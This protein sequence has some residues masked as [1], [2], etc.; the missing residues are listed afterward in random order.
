MTEDSPGSEKFLTLTRRYMSKGGQRQVEKAY[1]FAREAHRGQ[2][3]KSGES[4]AE[5]PIAVATTLAELEL[6]PDTVGAAL[7]HDVV[8]DTPFS[9]NDIRLQFGEQIAEIIDG[10]TKLDRFEFSS[11]EEQQAENMRKMLISMA[12]DVRVILI[13]LADRLHN[14]ETISALRPERQREISAETLEIYAPLAHRF[15]ISQ[16]EWKL[17]D[18]AFEVLY[19]K[20]YRQIQKMVSE[21]RMERETYMKQVT[22]QISEQLKKHRIKAEVSGRVKHFY[23]IYEKMVNRGIE[24]DEIMDLSAVRVMVESVKDCYGA[25]GVIHSTWKPV[26]GRFKDYIA[27]PKLNMYRSLH[28]VVMSLEGRPLEIQIRTREMHR[29]SE[30]GIAAHW[31]YKE[32]KRKDHGGRAWLKQVMDWQRELKD[33]TE[34]MKTLKIDLFQDEVFV[35]TPGGKLI[36]LSRGATPIDFAY[37][38][39]TE[40]GHNCV[41]A[42]VN[43]KMV[44]LTYQI[45]TGDIVNIMTSKTSKGPSRDWL[46]IVETSRARNKIRQWFSRERREDERQEGKE[47]LDREM[48]KRDLPIKGK[49]VER[50]LAQVGEDYHYARVEDLYRMIG[51]RHISPGHVV[52]KIAQYLGLEK[53]SVIVPE[54]EAET[55]PP[56]VRV[57][58][59]HIRQKI[60]VHGVDNALVTVARC[61]SPQPG[62]DIVGFVTRGRGVSVHLRECTNVRELSHEVDRMIDVTWE[63]ATPELRVAEIRVKAMDRPKLVRDITTVLGDQQINILSASFS[64]DS[65]HMASSKYLFEIAG[66]VHLEEIIKELRKIDSVYDVVE[67][68]ST[69]E[70]G[71]D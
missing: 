60:R 36:S 57:V 45:Q 33:P 50:V 21:R 56:G 2:C 28:T 12:G 62:D 27:M 20:R 47:V 42:K 13:K 1:R 8:E 54:T 55:P 67:V 30:F 15:G 26:P 10:V 70:M 69:E 9:L 58:D 34:F 61:C 51:A 38:V 23:S 32:S 49:E 48:R 18:F 63:E 4:Y 66:N 24:F 17:E 65:Q 29:T 11:R 37:A 71:T 25:L 43:G 52:N 5:H 6:D 39:H 7:L 68:G 19:P 3:R 41:G 40:V 44:P 14:M 64:I 59:D 22:E 31:L 53:K 46:N 16:I 35:F